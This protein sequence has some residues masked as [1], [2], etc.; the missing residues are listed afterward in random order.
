MKV[1]IYF[2]LLSLCPA[3]VMAKSVKLRPKGGIFEQAVYVKMTTDSNTTVYY[4]TDGSI[5]NTE[6]ILYVDS[7]LVSGVKVLRAV[8]YIN[9]KRSNINT[10]TYFTERPYTLP[11]VSVVSDPENFWSY[12]KGIYEKGCCADSTMPY[13]GAN[14][15]KSWE[16]ECNVEMYSIAGDRCFNQ[17][18]GMSLF[19]GYSRMLPQKSLAI[20]ARSK[21]GKSRFKYPIFSERKTKKYKSF[22]IRNSGGDFKRTQLR[23]A[24]MTQLAKPT[25]VAIQAYEPAV[26]YLNGKY[27]G[28]QNLREKISEH[29]LKDNFGVDKANV[30]ILRHNGV[31]RHGFSK[32]YK[33][34]KAFLRGNDLTDDHIL[35]SLSKFMNIH[36]Y[37]RYNIS[38]V[39]S[40]NKDAGGNIRYFREREPKAKWR[41]IFY[42]LD[43]GL[44]N[45][46]KKG[47]ASN[48]LQKFTTASSEKWPNPSWSTFIIRTLLQSKKL[49]HQYINSFCFYLSTCFSADTATELLNRMAKRI[50][51]EIVY[52]QKRWGSTVE[53]WH[54]NLEIVREFVQ[55]RPDFLYQHID[56]K[57]GLDTTIEISI[58][59]PE[60][61]ICDIKLNGLDINNDYKGK[62]FT[63][64]PQTISV[65]P[66]HD[67]RLIGWKNRPEQEDELKFTPIENLHFE[68]IIVPKDSSKFQDQI[69]INEINFKQVAN[70]STDD[71]I[72][73]YN[74]SNTDIDLNEW[75]LTDKSYKKGYIIEEGTIEANDFI[76]LSVNSNALVKLFQLDSEKVIGEMEF[77]LSKN[78][79]LLKLYD[80]DGLIVD[81]VLYD[82]S[83]AD[84][85]SA[86]S[87]AF[88]VPDSTK[89]NNNQWLVQAP[90]PLNLNP[91]HIQAVAKAKAEKERK[92][93]LK[94]TIIGGAAGL[95][96]ILIIVFIVRTR[97]K[98]N[99]LLTT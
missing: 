54:K 77:K 64:I 30:D 6:S 48:T 42:D 55:K 92:E 63:N 75:I 90:S 98:R 14:F 40:D 88:S 47:Y 37:L 87:L 89:S 4:T 50:E 34:L 59:L 25:G 17:L 24:F 95:L 9:G 43:M 21:Y 72:E 61:D 76:V 8:T 36:D 20:I 91:S 49:E 82:T 62:Y 94:N 15:W 3:L 99:S 80:A 53:S 39:Y 2:T 65:K 10:Q 57:F 13:Y 31:K 67:Y 51:P 84:I 29:Y 86:F 7:I 26:I 81:Y 27:W 41:W 23:D 83:L 44:S 28:I 79:E 66:K 1:L 56:E 85:D 70:D 74:N 73:L 35:D 68:P 16:Y 5:P 93:T 18:A 19:G 33:F 22:I 71:W 96:G 11:V 12:G 69:I 32:N 58:K 46:D 97:R 52:H 60:N 45:D 78:G 38:E